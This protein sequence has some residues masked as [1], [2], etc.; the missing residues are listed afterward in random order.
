MEMD[1]KRGDGDGDG[2]EWE[3]WWMMA[4]GYGGRNRRGLDGGGEGRAIFCV[5]AC[6][7][8][9]RLFFARINFQTRFP[10]DRVQVSNTETRGFL[11]R[12]PTASRFRAN[13][14][15]PLAPFSLFW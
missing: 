3:W 5:A 13:Q 1:D 12:P 11:V 8:P 9:S 6:N 2:S 10:S 15:A 7:E 14:R 4:A